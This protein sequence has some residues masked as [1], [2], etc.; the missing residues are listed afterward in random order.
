VVDGALRAF[1]ADP[2]LHLH[3]V[4]PP[5]VAE[6]VRAACPPAARAWLS[7]EPV[8]AVVGMADSPARGARP[9]TT[10]RAAMAAV[11]SGRA[12]GVVSA[13]ASG[14]TVTAAVLG[15]GRSSGIR[16]PALAALVPSGAGPVTLLDVGA[17]LDSTA[18]VLVQHAALGARYA[19][20][21][22]GL[23]TPRIGLLS[24]GTE[25]GKGDRM[26]RI[27]DEQMR[28]TVPGYVGN[29]EG[30]DVPLGGP[31][32]VVVTDGFTGNVLLK[33][34]EGGF[35]LAGGVAATSD[36]PR[37]AALLGVDG[38][39]VVCHGAAS[40]A[41]VASGIL[42]AARLHRARQPVPAGTATTTWLRRWR[43]G[44]S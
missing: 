5:E 36:V 15:L 38:L 3:L 28:R 21:L 17:S 25:E 20:T 13:G 11:A 43:E 30:H 35:A 33:G 40:G 2:D 42:L 39:V 31:A 9:D 16:R 41:D 1:D 44:S 8:Q 37:G 4:G 7:S 12:D 19:A 27:A 22:L 32:D 26:R 23:E 6:E 18:A 29:V 10:V 14:A 34:I 24:V